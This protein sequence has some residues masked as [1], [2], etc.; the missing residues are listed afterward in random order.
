MHR[1]L[2]SNSTLYCSGYLDHW[3]LLD[4]GFHVHVDRDRG[5]LSDMRRLTQ[6]IDVT[7]RDL[8]PLWTDVWMNADVPPAP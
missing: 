6:A 8:L 7:V 5:V 1:L 2:I 4:R 3:V